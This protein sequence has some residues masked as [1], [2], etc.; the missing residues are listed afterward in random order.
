MYPDTQYVAPIAPY[1]HILLPT[2]FSPAS[3]RALHT[4]ILLAR[5][6]Q[7]HLTVVHVLP[8]LTRLLAADLDHTSADMLIQL[9]DGCRTD[10]FARLA[11]LVSPYPKL[12]MYEVVEGEPAGAIASTATRLGVDVIVLGCRQRR[13]L[14]S[15]YRRR[16]TTRLMRRAP[17]PVL[18]IRA[19]AQDELIS[20]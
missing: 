20:E 14:L 9:L 11:A 7:A 2:D 4:A 17:C 10:A 12:M 19:E 5:H 16:V 1:D 8:R 3:L 13:R 15:C 6:H 18:L